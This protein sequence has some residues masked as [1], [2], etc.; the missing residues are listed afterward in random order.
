MEERRCSPGSVSGDLVIAQRHTIA[1]AVDIC[2]DRS[3]PDSPTPKMQTHLINLFIL[4]ALSVRPMMTAS[5]S[6]VHEQEQ[7]PKDPCWFMALKNGSFTSEMLEKRTNRETYGY[8]TEIPLSEAIRIFNEETQCKALYKDYPP[9]TE[10]ELIAAIVAGADY[11]KQGKIWLAQR[12]AL[13]KIAA[14][15]VMPK[16][17]LLVVESGGRVQESPLRPFGTIQAKGMT[18][19]LFL[20]LEKSEHGHVAKPEQTLIVRKTFSRVEIVK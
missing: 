14:R 9:L 20:G 11:G 3:F 19:T 13:W 7:K 18:I 6:L 2:N 4:A 10:D 12:D 17:A 5:A 16:G 8:P 1:G 15:K